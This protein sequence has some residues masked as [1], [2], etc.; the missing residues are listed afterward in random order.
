MEEYGVSPLVLSH[1]A[2]HVG[3]SY[4]EL[5]DVSRG[6]QHV[7]AALAYAGERRAR[8]SI[9][10]ARALG[11]VL[12]VALEPHKHFGVVSEAVGTPEYER[13]RHVAP[14]Y[15]DLNIL[16][17]Q[18]GNFGGDRAIGQSLYMGWLSFY[19][20]ARIGFYSQAFHR[21]QLIIGT[22]RMGTPWRVR[23]SRRCRPQDHCGGAEALIEPLSV[24][25]RAF[26]LIQQYLQKLTHGSK[27]IEEVTANVYM[28]HFL[29]WFLHGDSNLMDAETGRS[30][31]VHVLAQHVERSIQSSYRHRQFSADIAMWANN[32]G[33]FGATAILLGLLDVASTC[34]ARYEKAVELTQMTMRRP[35][36]VKQKMQLLQFQGK[37]HQ[38]MEY[39]AEL[40]RFYSSNSRP[41]VSMSYNSLLAHLY[42]NTGSTERALRH[43]W[44]AAD[45]LDRLVDAG[46]EPWFH[47]ASYV[48][49][50]EV[51]CDAF[52]CVRSLGLDR[53]RLH[54]VVH[55]LLFYFWSY[56]CISPTTLG[57]CWYMQGRAFSIVG[58]AEKAR[59]CLQKGLDAS[60]AFELH[61]WAQKNRA[62]LALAYD[63]ELARLRSENA[64]MAALLK[65]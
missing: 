42:W 54:R 59:V 19:H 8:R 10:D 16:M 65:Q 29:C 32:R 22:T 43:F 24:L 51:C 11:M 39:S 48:L 17:L 5:M 15:N 53:E 1:W 25:Y 20:H 55:K 40:D 6:T 4:M 50:F 34:L 58:D 62:G 9:M 47:N 7:L 12:R 31:G 57:M 41:K 26:F 52:A 45:A 44:A 61:Y 63:D 60:K 38:S 27:Y 21:L 49:L 46:K 13:S 35:V 64:Q 56:R 37:F 36:I 28:N 18:N 33:A 30:M 3:K 23:R 14:T 2:R